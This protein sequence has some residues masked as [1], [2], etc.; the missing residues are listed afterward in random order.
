MWV[1]PNELEKAFRI[2]KICNIIRRRLNVFKSNEVTITN[3]KNLAIL[4]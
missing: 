4:F 2:F 1:R 3:I